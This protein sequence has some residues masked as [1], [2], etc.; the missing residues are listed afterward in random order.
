MLKQIYTLFSKIVAVGTEKV[1]SEQTQK[2][3]IIVNLLSFITATMAVLISSV[4]SVVTHN[5]AIFVPAMIESIMFFCIPLLN[6]WGKHEAAGLALL[7]CHCAWVVFFGALLGIII[8]I[9]MVILFVFSTALLI[10]Q[11]R[12]PI[13]ISIS[14][15]I[16]CLILMEANYYH[17]VFQPVDLGYE[18]QF[19]LRWLAIASILLLNMLVI[20][21]YKRNI[22]EHNNMLEKLVKARTAEL[23]QANNSK[24]IF[25]RQTSHEIRTPLN[26]IYG[27][28][29]LLQHDVEEGKLE[30]NPL[31]T[32][33]YSASH[34]A[35]QIINDV[36]ELS[37]IEAGTFIEVRESSFALKPY[38][39]E[40]VQIHQY[41]AVAK[42]V[43]IMRTFGLDLPVGIVSD[44]L[45]LGQI[46]SNLLSNAIKFARPDTHV[47]LNVYS[48]DNILR[49]MVTD[50]GTGIAPEMLPHIFD[51]FVSKGNDFIAGTGLGLPIT[52][53][54]AEL[55][56]GTIRVTS[57]K[58]EGSCFIVELPLHPA[59][60]EENNTAEEVAQFAPAFYPAQTALVIDDDDM[61]RAL[62]SHFLADAGMQVF[63]AANGIE[64]LAAT[65]THNP[66]IIVMDAQMPQLDGESTLKELKQ[67]PALKNIPV[68]I[69]SGDVYNENLR[70]NATGAAEFVS[71]PIHRDE[72]L[73]AVGK[74]I[75]LK[76]PV[77]T[78][79]SHRN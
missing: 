11:K 31:F 68:I 8:E 29:Q 21:L 74:Y 70:H 12:R 73:A 38:I 59:E 40:L 64:G 79:L 54:L 7:I 71:K 18:S 75:L 53:H 16:A 32:H 28:A 2:G 3:I 33:L 24:R 72:L 4:Y 65:F 62:I 22:L 30:A 36:M 5:P 50:E 10:Y 49:I 61:S 17:P 26:A 43:T 77:K 1:T 76:R 46:I 14:V 55:L 39:T 6:R 69:V 41:V 58:G 42:N 15:A 52:R 78:G 13:I 56:G 67:I 45:K 34:T 35:R 27:I 20:V 66:A 48:Q 51:P 44:K 19:I 60:T 47:Y 57:S 37:R 23:E 25:L 9:R 63:T